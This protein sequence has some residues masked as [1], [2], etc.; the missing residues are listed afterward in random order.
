MYAY[1]SLSSSLSVSHF[2]FEISQGLIATREIDFYSLFS[3]SPFFVFNRWVNSIAK[4][5]ITTS[6]CPSKKISEASPGC[7]QN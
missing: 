4:S 5:K 1:C 2:S 3:F 7:N 6:K